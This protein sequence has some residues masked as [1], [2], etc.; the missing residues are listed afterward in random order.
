MMHPRLPMLF[1]L[2]E[3]HDL[4]EKIGAHLGLALQEQ[5]ERA[6]EDGEYKISPGVS[7]RDRDVFVLQSL[8]GDARHSVHDKL[9][10]LLFFIGALKDAAAR[11][12]TA[13]VPY[14]CYARKDMKTKPRDPV[15]TRYVAQLFEAV[16]TDRVIT[17]DVHNLAAFQNA[18]RCRTEHLEARPLFVRHFAPLVENLEVAVIS[19][20]I[21]G[22]KR[23]EKF[24]QHLGLALQREA[25]SGFM[26]KHRSSGVVSGE[27]LVGDV[28]GKVVIIIDDLIS[29]GGT[30]LRTARACRRA[31]AA[32]VYAAATHGVFTG[33]A[34]QVFADPAISGLVVA[35]TIPPFRLTAE[36]VRDKL[37]V[38]DGAGLIAEAIRRLQS[39]GS[40]VELLSP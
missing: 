5:L 3:S 29:T 27:T 25:G 33:E 32:V 20:D 14:L 39:G 31:G 2:S 10:R 18:F 24:R 30:M 6:F 21:G 11:T 13:V 4:G 16:G 12:V 36:A 40:L 15:N 28:V 8:Y 37:T 35:D 7:V 34:G 9:T 22:I 26:E 38:L 17:M 23:A 19:P 1:A